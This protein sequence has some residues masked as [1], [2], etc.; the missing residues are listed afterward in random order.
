MIDSLGISYVP[1][2]FP[3]AS[4]V[5]GMRAIIPDIT[6]SEVDRIWAI[7]KAGVLAEEIP[8]Y[9]KDAKG[10]IT[11]PILQYMEKRGI[12]RQ[13]MVAWLQATL[14]ATDSFG[15]RWIDPLTAKKEK[16]Q[17]VQTVKGAITETAKTIGDAAGLA[18]KPILDNVKWVAIAALVLGGGYIA[19]Q[20]GMFKQIKKGAR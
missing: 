14:A 13:K 15:F 5:K 7:Y 10:E 9:T 19:Y 2:T 18:T 16:D 17:A 20:S 8:V 12:G 1:F 4:V 6:G 11:S 3:T